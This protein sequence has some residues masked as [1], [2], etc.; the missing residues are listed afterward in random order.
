M[1]MRTDATPRMPTKS[2]NSATTLSACYMYYGGR[3]W[4]DQICM[5]APPQSCKINFTIA[6][7]TQI[8]VIFVSSVVHNRA[9]VDCLRGVAGGQS[10]GR[11][12]RN[13]LKTTRM[14]VTS[15]CGTM[16]ARTVIR[17]NELTNCILH[18]GRYSS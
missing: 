15:R 9:I 2:N 17:R 7:R 13:M 11:N 1:V 14:T 16:G 18:M 4:A 5:W 12:M 6:I 8:C 3:E 10:V